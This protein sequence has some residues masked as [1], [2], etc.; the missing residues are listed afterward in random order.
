LT[1][2]LLSAALTCL[3]SLSLGQGVLA[4]CG[5]RRWSWLAAPVGLSALMLL[6][7][8]AIHVPGRA[9][10]TAVVTLVLVLAGLALWWR[11]PAQRPP[12][13]GLLAGLPVALLV[14]VPFL[15]AG[16]AGTLGMSFDN[17]MAA[18]LLLAEGYRSAAVARIWPLLPEYP[19]GPHALTATV[20]Q[21][22]GVRTDLAFAGVTAASPLLLAWTALTAVR[23][24]GWAGKLVLATVVGVPFL[25]ASYYA[26]GAFKE[27]MEA[28]FALGTV[29]A[30]DS[31]AEGLARRRYVP[32]ALIWAG[33]VSVYSLQGLVWPGLFVAAW[34]AVRAGIRT[35]QASARQA[36]LQLREELVPGA[37]GVAVLVIVLIP[38][39]PRVEKFV[40]KGGISNGIGKSNLGNLAGP[41]SG[42]EAFGAWTGYDFRTTPA[43]AVSAGA[44]AG[45]VLVLVLIGAALLARRGRWIVPLAAALAMLIWVY[46][47]HNQSPYVAAKALVI[48]SPLL[49]TAAT[50]P[51]VERG[52][53]PST[54]RAW[55]APLL[56]L[57]LLGRVVDSSWEALRAGKVGSTDHL[58]ELRSLQPAL[59]GQTV[60]SLGDDDFID[61][62]LPESHV[63]AAYFAG[64]TE[65]PLTPAKG[66]IYGQPLDFD[67][68]SAKTLNEYDWVLT[69]R[70]AAASQAPAG[71]VP[72]RTTR[73]YELWRR[74]G[75]VAPRKILAEGPQA[76]A[77]LDCRTTAGRSLVRAGGVA[78]LHPAAS[79]VPVP[80]LAPG[81]S[82]T[83]ELPLSSG[84]WT[85]E[86]PYLS[87]LPLEVRA[88]GLSMVLPA[89]LER[90]GP[91]WQIGKVTVTAYGKVPVT[92]RLRRP[93]LAPLSDVATPV[94][95]VATQQAPERIVPLARACGKAVDWYQG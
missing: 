92:F 27:V 71:L 81:A 77:I 95:L 5:A 72:V 21:G 89:N 38:Q 65:V 66:F 76:A 45:L 11:V 88:A 60:L 50:L 91:R 90:P 3:G 54:W 78:A 48:V 87:P 28:L 57:V 4:L 37:L 58:A 62:E 84:T 68:V 44:W 17:D 42:W 52:L 7:V 29:V 93:W 85:L 25:I 59:R 10:T 94:S 49:L 46:A 15:A 1:S 61:W 33:A 70:D 34:L 31:R 83:V 22:L 13:A 35:W 40:S 67:T 6:A 9:T 82:A 8:P 24:A 75:V 20:A 19:L 55:A 86:T 64:L 73:F 30:L 69:T 14:L 79:E 18:H 63:V 74:T 32:M 80:A 41:L 43:S 2:I 26:E 47:N 51:L 12:L 23:R 16:R 56:A 36:L 39:L 53:A